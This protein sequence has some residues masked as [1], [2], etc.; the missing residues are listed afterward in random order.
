MSLLNLLSKEKLWRRVVRLM[1]VPTVAFC[2]QKNEISKNK[3]QNGAG[4]KKSQQHQPCPVEDQPTV[5]LQKLQQL[6]TPIPSFHQHQSKYRLL[7]L[8][9]IHQRNN[10]ILATAPLNPLASCGLS[11]LIQTNSIRSYLWS[12]SVH[13]LMKTITTTAVVPLL[14]QNLLTLAYPNN[15]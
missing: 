4:N 14:S 7:Q 13:N 2:R 15:E 12:A 11:L 5:H 3:L 9:L 10:N 6:Q 8:Y 1:H